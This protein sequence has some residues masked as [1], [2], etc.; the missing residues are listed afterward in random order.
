MSIENRV[1]IG[2]SMYP[3]Y[4][5]GEIVPVKNSCKKFIIGNCYLFSYKNTTYIHRLYKKHKNSLQLIGDNSNR[6]QIVN[7]EKVIAE[8]VVQ[9]NYISRILIALVNI[10]FV[11]NSPTTYVRNYIRRRIIRILLLILN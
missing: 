2:S 6:V 7:T 4:K 5:N 3:F 11:T 8:P 9:T 10:F 1:V